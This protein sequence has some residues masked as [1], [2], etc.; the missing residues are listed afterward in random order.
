MKIMFTFVGELE[1]SMEVSI[2]NPKL[3]SDLDKLLNFSKSQN[4]YPQYTDNKVRRTERL[5]NLSQ[6]TQG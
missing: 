6:V 3:F 4:P 5:S 1:A 2:Y